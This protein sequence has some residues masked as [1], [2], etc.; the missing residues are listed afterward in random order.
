MNNLALA[1]GL[2][3]PGV[4]ET[5]GR[6]LE[7]L[8]LPFMAG[9]VAEGSHF[10]AGLAFWLVV[11]A[12]V[13]ICLIF[14]G[15]VLPT[16][17]ALHV[18]KRHLARLLSQAKT[19]EDRRRIFAEA[20][21]EDVDPLLS[22][23]RD[24]AH[25]KWLRK[26]LRWFGNEES[27]RLAWSEFKETL[28]DEDES[29]EALRNT[30]RP[31]GY[32]LRAV[33]NPNRYASLAGI[34]VSIG[35]LLTFVGIIAVLMKAGCEINED[36]YAVC[37]AYQSQVSAVEARLGQAPD[38]VDGAVVQDEE[39]VRAAVISIVSGAAS[40][41]YASIGGLFA[42]I[43]LKIF[44]SGFAWAVRKE[45]EKLADLLESGL[46][47]VPEQ[48]LAIEQLDIVREQSTQ[49][50]KFNT[51]LAVAVGEA[52][53]PVT[54]RLGNIQ[55][56]LET[57]S[58]ATLDALQ[59]GVGDAVNNMAGGEIREL[60]RVLGDLKSELGGLSQKLSDGG[61]AAANQMAEA[62][63]ALS[64]MSENLKSEFEVLNQQ[65]REAA[66]SANQEMMRSAET[67]NEALQNS[68]RQIDEAGTTN[69]RRLE[70][71][72]QKLEGLAGGL[73]EDAQ[74]GFQSALAEAAASTGTA[75]KEA[76]A[77]LRVAFE[78]ASSE[79]RNSVDQAT[80]K[81]ASLAAGLE[82]SATAASSHAETMSKAANATGDA[83]GAIQE[84]ASGLRNVSQPLSNSVKS[85]EHAAQSV[86]SA[87]NGLN[88]ASRSAIE[89]AESLANK[90]GQ[91]AAAAEEAWTDYIERFAEVDEDLG[92]VLSE[93]TTALSQNAE[94]MQKYVTDLD[95]QLSHAVRQF[96]N[97]VQPLNDMADNIETAAQRLR[98]ERRIAAE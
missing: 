78:E 71:I 18:R 37:S 35:L 44:I 53:S 36:G 46:V 51:D 42:S 13:T 81:I 61:D 75:A 27:L 26:F 82:R 52:I 19:D 11:I 68:L 83:S 45:A 87:V 96:S 66:S 4:I 25:S 86:E 63:D 50:K 58:Q 2:A 20:F 80:E 85:L 3:D 93:I 79:W 48:R 98:D 6:F 60:G 67:M 15:R 56:S 91:T 7:R 49:L 77:Q 16:W 17:L 47:F 64:A 38:F 43:L 5:A 8:L 72:G 31:H 62:A 40:K 76:G 28:I 12:I 94:A 97:A 32:F 41:F 59:T 73:A 65:T 22:Y 89:R 10:A 29:A 74:R 70:E 24:S 1:S 88:E 55:T 9:F 95:G 90:M 69:G 30:A 33:R 21:H 23:G 14:V 54:E 92:K 34:F 57:Q 84:A 39:N